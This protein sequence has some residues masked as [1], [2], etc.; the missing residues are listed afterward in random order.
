ML[1]SGSA[2]SASVFVMLITV[3]NWLQITADES[4]AD[5]ICYSLSDQNDEPAA[6]LIQ[7][8]CEDILTDTQLRNSTTQVCIT[9]VIFHD[10]LASTII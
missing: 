7:M 9:C 2:D 5:Y 3:N 10:N 4:R 1:K 8:N 6:V